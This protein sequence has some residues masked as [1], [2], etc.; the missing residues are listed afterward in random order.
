MEQIS[1]PNCNQDHLFSQN[2]SFRAE[3]EACAADLHV[4]L[5]CNYHDPYADNQ[6][7]ET[8]ADPVAKKDRANLCE[9]WKPRLLGEQED[10]QASNAA[11]AKLAALFGDASQPPVATHSSSKDEALKKLNALFKKD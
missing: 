3:C 2:L 8:I 5:T 11:K 1:C 10:T 9:Y 6:C 7:R 4:C